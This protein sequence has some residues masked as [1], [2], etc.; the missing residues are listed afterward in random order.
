M[1]RVVA[2][3]GSASGIGAATAALLRQRG[4][5]VIGVDRADAGVEVVADLSTAQGRAEAVAA[6]TELTGG[7]LD[8]LVTCA[9]LSR[10]GA[11]QVSV[12]Y[13]GTTELVD[14][15]RPALAASSAPRVALVG[16]ISA[17]QPHDAALVDACLVGDEPA[18]LAL[19]ESALADGRPHEIYSSTKAALARW[20]RRVSVTADFAGAGIALNAI[21]PGVVLTPMTEELVSDP[22]WR[23]VMDRAVPMPLNGYASPE[24]IAYALAWLLSVENSHMAG[25]VVYVDGGAEALARP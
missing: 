13:F 16:S 15:L 4:D 23:Q 11:P 2:V 21:A 14:G 24:T 17:I 3:T 20:L 8:G 25:Q 22:Q 7:V 19:A 18:A 5:R 1:S 9:G 6:V 10:A 12:N